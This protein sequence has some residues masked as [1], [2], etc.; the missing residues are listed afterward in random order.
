MARLVGAGDRGTVGIALSAEESWGQ[1]QSH[2][3]ATKKFG[4]TAP[5]KQIS[6]PCAMVGEA[7]YV[8]A[9]S[10]LNRALVACFT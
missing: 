5:D 7:A 10:I 9:V 6:L 3:S 2:E 4:G 8:V 1:V